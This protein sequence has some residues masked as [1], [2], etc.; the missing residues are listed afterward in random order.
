[1]IKDMIL[2]S[3]HLLPCLTLLTLIGQF[4]VCNAGTGK[5]GLIFSNSIGQRMQTYFT[6]NHELP[7]N[8]FSV[9]FLLC[10]SKL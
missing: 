1:M 8:I 10:I 3:H 2:L 9:N 6:H 7:Y 4:L 5:K